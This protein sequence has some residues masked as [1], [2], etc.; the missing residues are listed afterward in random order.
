MG[1]HLD[2]RPQRARLSHRR[3]P[4]AM[5]QMRRHWLCEQQEI[6]TDQAQGCATGDN[7]MRKRILR[8]APARADVYCQLEQQ[9]DGS[10]HVT[11][12]EPSTRLLGLVETQE[13]AEALAKR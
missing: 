9:P 1:Q 5:L 2:G 7:L 3:A 13:A 4:R 8:Y 6:G 12:T 10:W 11:H